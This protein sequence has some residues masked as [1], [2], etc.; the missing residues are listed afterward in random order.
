MMLAFWAALNT[1]L[2]SPA[3]RSKAI[4]EMPETA[5]SA[6]VNR[7]P[8]APKRANALWCGLNVR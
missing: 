5:H 4:P 2:N 8:R 6:P 7:N 3:I 1:S